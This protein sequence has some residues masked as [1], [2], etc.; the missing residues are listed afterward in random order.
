MLQDGPVDRDLNIVISQS[1]RKVE[2]A[3]SV[4]DDGKRTGERSPR[5]K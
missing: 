3:G 1:Q 5:V 4:V 2:E